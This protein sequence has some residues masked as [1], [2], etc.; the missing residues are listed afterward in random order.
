[1]T[2]YTGKARETQT[3]EPVDRVHTAGPI[4]TR[5][6]AA[7]IDVCLAQHTG[8]ASNTQTREGVKAVNTRGAILAWV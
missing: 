4:L 5:I 2:Q 3:G 8:I 1:L 6:R 7:F